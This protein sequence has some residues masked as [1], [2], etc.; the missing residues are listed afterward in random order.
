[1][2]FSFSPDSDASL[3]R[4]EDVLSLSSSP[5]NSRVNLQNGHSN[6]FLCVYVPLFCPGKIR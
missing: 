2:E 5:I 3:D 6:K 1:M 4:N